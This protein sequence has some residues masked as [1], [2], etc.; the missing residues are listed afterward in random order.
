MGGGSSHGSVSGGYH[1]GSYG[2]ARG[3]SIGSGYRGGL[4]Y[5]GGNRYGGRG[6]GYGGFGHRGGYWPYYGWGY[7]GFGFGYSSCP[8]D[9]YGYYGCYPYSYYDPGT[10]NSLDTYNDPGYVSPPAPMTT[11][12]IPQGGTYPQTAAPG[13]YDG[14]AH[15][16]T[17]SYDEYG[18]ETSASG[19]SGGSA[20]PIYL[21]A[22]K[23]GQIQGASSYWVTGQ[24]LHYVTLDL[25]EKQVALD[26]I[27]RT[28]T[29][30]LNRE[31]RVR[32][33]L[34]AE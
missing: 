1:G 6:Y 20:S 21:I 7:P 9:Y 3:G 30:Q 22:L 23:D 19:G 32:L 34:P 24:I 33:N 5:G 8:G 14:P 28:L 4:S 10:Y 13:S 2:G 17:H 29:D 15:P 18:Q 26:S 31:R 12:A 27:D 25:Q 16:V 11:Y